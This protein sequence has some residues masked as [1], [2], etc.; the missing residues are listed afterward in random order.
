AAVLIV[1]MHVCGQA[2]ARSGVLYELWYATWPLRVPLFVLVA[3]YFSSAEPLRGRRAV[4]VLRNVFGVYLVADLVATVLAWLG[5]NEWSYT[6]AHA[7][8][9]LWFLLSLFWWRAMLPLRAH[10]RY[11][12]V[13]AV[14]A[15]VGVG[16]VPNIGHGFSASRTIA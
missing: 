11:L 7:P 1:V 4:A 5:G 6:P 9:A 2:M 10:V 14:I 3:G 13:V 16:L 15:A 8:F 12:G